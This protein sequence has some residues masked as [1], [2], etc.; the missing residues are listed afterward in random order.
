MAKIGIHANG[1]VDPFRQ[2]Q[3]EA[4]ALLSCAEYLHEMSLS[5]VFTLRGHK[6][7]VS[8]VAWGS[9]DVLALGSLDEND[10]II[11]SK[12]GS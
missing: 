11:W 9:G 6:G 8:C 7:R 12:D 2:L 10:I 1:S 4:R 3:D 5:P